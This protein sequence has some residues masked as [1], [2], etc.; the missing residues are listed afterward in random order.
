MGFDYEDSSRALAAFEVAQELLVNGP[1]GPPDQA[2]ATGGLVLAVADV[3][4]NYDADGW[5]GLF[6]GRSLVTCTSIGGT[7]IYGF[8]CWRIGVYLR[9]DNVRTIRALRFPRSGIDRFRPSCF[10]G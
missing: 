8:R 10:P 1:A 4:A 3:V 5:G 2:D 7:G 6:E 9:V